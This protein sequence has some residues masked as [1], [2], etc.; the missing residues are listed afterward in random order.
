MGV[1][2]LFQELRERG[3]EH[4]GQVGSAYVEADGAV[5][6]FRARAPHA[7]MACWPACAA[8]RSQ[9]PHPHAPIAA[10]T[11]SPPLGKS[12]SSQPTTKSRPSRWHPATMWAEQIRNRHR[13]RTFARGHTNSTRRTRQCH[14]LTDEG[15]GSG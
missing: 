2:E 9:P 7:A 5:T 6:V 3:V 14:E 11:I 1:S 12:Q 4:L 8:A 10:T 15:S 13:R